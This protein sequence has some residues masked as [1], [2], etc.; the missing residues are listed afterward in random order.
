METEL[1]KV[2]LTNDE[3]RQ[4]VTF[5]KHFTMVNLMESLGVFN[6]KDGSVEI[7]FDRLGQIAK[8][9]IHSHF[10]PNKV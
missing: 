7:H 2:Y 5:R 3:A 9:D 6:I 8:V 10:R 4:F 1:S